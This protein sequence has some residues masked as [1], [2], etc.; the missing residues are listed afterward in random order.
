MYCKNCDSHEHKK[1]DMFLTHKGELV[2]ECCYN[3]DFRPDKRYDPTS[4]T[5]WVRIDG[6]SKT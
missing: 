2:C 6:K 1:D 4:K 3:D 5:D